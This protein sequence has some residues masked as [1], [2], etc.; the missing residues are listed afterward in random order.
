MGVTI[1]CLVLHILCTILWA[2]NAI[3]SN[4]KT[5]KIIYAVCS[6]LWGICVVLDIAK[7][8]IM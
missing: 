6:I 8:S 7:L 2:I 1:T 5:Q 4:N 3:I